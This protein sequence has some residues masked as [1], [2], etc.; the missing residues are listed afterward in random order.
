[1]SLPEQP[2]PSTSA[3][4]F[5]DA[6]GTLPC[7]LS[8]TAGPAF[9]NLQPYEKSHGELNADVISNRL[10]GLQGRH[11]VR[12]PEQLHLH[13]VLIRLNLISS[14]N[15]LSLES[16]LEKQRLREPV[17]ITTFGT[18]ISGFATWNTAI[19]NGSAAVDCIEYSVTDV[20]AIEFIL[21]RHKSRQGWNDF[22]R[23]RL[24]LELEPMLQKRALDHQI[25]GGRYK[26]SAKLPKPEQIDVRRDIARV[27]GVCPRNVS[28][29]K[30]ILQKGHP[31]LIE[32]L[33]IGTLRIH[34]A[35][36]WCA[37]SEI[38]QREQFAKYAVERATN[39]AIRQSLT[40]L[41]RKE[42]AVDPLAVLRKLRKREVQRPGTVMVR[43][44]RLQ[45]TVVLLGRDLF[46]SHSEREA[47]D[48]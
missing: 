48:R 7:G 4:Q 29:V 40:V 13:P 46:S 42:G 35:L 18:I 38:Q 10:R 19:S 36:Q 9:T 47:N 12:S 30:V 2:L 34:R 45:R 3:R 21:S 44:T 15:E 14:V 24:A 6:R 43:R 33:A 32:A 11:V 5:V 37:F 28:N 8:K 26:G 1:M 16:E 23:I 25:A 31:A 22:V 17:L 39:R 27:A 20:E 41:R